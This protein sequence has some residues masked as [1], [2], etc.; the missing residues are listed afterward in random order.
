M[1]PKPPLIKLAV[2]NGSLPQLNLVIL[3]SIDNLMTPVLNLLLEIH[4]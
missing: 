3:I 4:V 1:V 2:F